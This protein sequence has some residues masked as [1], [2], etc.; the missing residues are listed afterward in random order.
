MPGLEL[1]NHEPSRRR[2][3]Q[4][5]QA[6]NPQ[7]HVERVCSSPTGSADRLG[8][9]SPQ[10]RKNPQESRAEGESGAMWT[11]YRTER[12]IYPW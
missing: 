10:L 7:V 8:G 5:R 6:L 11:K 3:N 1:G 4:E 9:G 2:T 12:T